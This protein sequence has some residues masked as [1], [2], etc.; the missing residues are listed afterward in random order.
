LGRP[1]RIARYG[2]HPFRDVGPR[3]RPGP[4]VGVRRG[5]GVT[6]PSGRVTIASGRPRETGL[7]V[8]SRRG[9]KGGGSG[10]GGTSA[11]DR[12]RA[13]REAPGS[14]RCVGYVGAWT[15]VG[16]P[17]LRRPRQ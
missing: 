5:S 11:W 17:A 15:Q 1:P 12:H 7:A 4:R 6:R 13:G 8:E 14:S 2:R 3:P 10:A 9:S 16:L